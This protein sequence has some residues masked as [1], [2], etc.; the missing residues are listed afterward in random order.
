[1]KDVEKIVQEHIALSE[2]IYTLA[3]HHI[4]E[5]TALLEY[6]LSN[7]KISDLLTCIICYKQR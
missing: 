1:M 5:G 2:Q 6:A 3:K 4:D 7:I